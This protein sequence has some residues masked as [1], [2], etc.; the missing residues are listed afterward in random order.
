MRRAIISLASASVR[1]GRGG[2]SNR[3]SRLCPVHRNKR[4]GHRRS[5]QTDRLCGQDHRRQAARRLV[6]GQRPCRYRPCSRLAIASELARLRH[7]CKHHGQQRDLHGLR[8]GQPAL[9]R[10][11]VERRLS[12]LL[13]RR[14]PDLDRHQPQRNRRPR[15]HLR[16]RRQ[17]LLRPAVNRHLPRPGRGVALGQRR[18]DLG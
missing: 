11:R 15:R 9:F 16:R 3:R 10:L 2:H 7:R 14:R 8:P 18:R 5:A 17:R 1:L 6:T 13:Q 4:T 12:R